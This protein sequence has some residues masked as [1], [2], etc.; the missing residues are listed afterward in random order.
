MGRW[1][2]L[3]RTIKWMLLGVGALAVLGG[4]VDFLIHDYDPT[5]VLYKRLKAD[6][7]YVYDE[8]DPKYLKTDPRDLISL[9]TPE[10]VAAM[11]A[12]LID[13][14]WGGAGFPATARPETVEADFD[15][16][17]LG[18]LP[19]LASVERLTV[20]M[21]SGVQSYLYHLKPASNANGELVIYHHGFAGEIRD[22]PHVLGGL[23]GRGYAVLGVNMM[24]YGGNSNSIKTAAGERFNLHFDLD[25][26][27]QPLRYHFQPLVVGVN[28]VL[29]AG[30]YKA[31]H[32]VGFSAGAFFTTVMA[33][34]DPR[35]AR[36][37]PIAGVYPIYLRQGQEIQPRLP[38]YYPPLLEIASYPELFVLGAS[39]E[40]RRQ[41]Q[42]FNRYDRCCFNN[43]K[44]RLYV[45]A[46]ADAVRKIGGGGGFGVFIDETHADHR[47]SETAL[48]TLLTDLA[49]P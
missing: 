43:T 26:I 14:I 3:R 25:K 19:N 27:D 40:G 23:L 37:Y 5:R 46:V 15:D 48:K 29:G 47:I 31:I 8:I 1:V 22:M 10:D 11:R 32:M 7:P 35:I 4:A 39:G 9:A 41:L 30:D 33:A 24:A 34:I 38:S 18:A 21:G 20:S 6:S 42:I 49:A 16:E 2:T 13:M 44:G 45:T 28:H 12:R 36:S 17:I